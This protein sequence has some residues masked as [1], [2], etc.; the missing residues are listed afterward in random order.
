MGPGYRYGYAAIGHHIFVEARF[1]G[2]AAFPPGVLIGRAE[3]CR[4]FENVHGT[5]ADVLARAHFWMRRLYAD[6]NAEYVPAPHTWL[7]KGSD[8]D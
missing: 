4:L 8:N 2:S 3:R 6:P 5:H 1:V 7:H